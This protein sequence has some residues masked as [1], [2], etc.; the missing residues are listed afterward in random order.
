[1]VTRL[2]RVLNEDLQQLEGISEFGFRHDSETYLP[3]HPHPSTLSKGLNNFCRVQVPNTIPMIRWCCTVLSVIRYN[4]LL[5]Y[6][7]LT[8]LF[9]FFFITRSV[10]YSPRNLRICGG[11]YRIM[12]Y[13]IYIF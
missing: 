3:S 1:M 7:W 9:F 6:G 8:F 10:T 2:T 5:R 13:G 12:I 11:R 4:V